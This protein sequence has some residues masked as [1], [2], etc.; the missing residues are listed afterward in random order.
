M[1]IFLAALGFVCYTVHMSSLDDSPN[2]AKSSDWQRYLDWIN[3]DPKNNSRAHP[4][5]ESASDSC[6]PS[7]NGESGSTTFPDV[8]F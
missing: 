3:T 5:F 7:V 4:D 8:F 6:G 1:L 2:K